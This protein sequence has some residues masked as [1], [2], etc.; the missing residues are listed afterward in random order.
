MTRRAIDERWLVWAFFAVVAG[1]GLLVYDDYGISWDEPGLVHY[2]NLLLEH[3]GPGGEWETYSNLRYYGPVGPVLLAAADKVLPGPALPGVH[4]VSFAFFLAGAAAFY[5]LCRYQFGSRLWGLAG[6]AALVLSPRVFAHGMVNPKDMPLMTMFVVAVYLL[7]RY[8][9][10]RNVWW[11]VACGA[12]TGIAFGIRITG[13]FVAVLVVLGVGID[14]VRRRDKEF[15]RS[16]A[17]ALAA[18]FAF[19]AAVGYAVWPFLWTDPVGNLRETFEVMTNFLEGPPVLL[20]RGD[21]VGV[22]DLPWHYLFVWIG[23]TTPPLYLLVAAAGLFPA[24]RG[25]ARRTRERFFTIHLAWLLVPL[26]AVAIRRPPLY[27]T[28]RQALFVYPALLLLAVAGARALVGFL[29]RRRRSRALLRAAAVF[30]A[31]ALIWIVA[32]MFRLHPYQA[33]YFNVFAG[34]APHDEFE[35]D[36]WGLSYTE[37]Q[38]RLLRAE[39]G[40]LK[41]FN[42]SGPPGGALEEVLSEEDAERIE[43]LALPDEADFSLCTPRPPSFRPFG[44]VAFTIERDG[45]LLLEA[46][47]LR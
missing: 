37:A 40:E 9:D 8:L 34:D 10:S 14:V 46:V 7:V 35:A 26:A 41:V 32:T 4:L 44:H 1:F 17:I 25:V 30:V 18:Y 6:A 39:E 31:C 28:G 13:A 5:A 38:E 16:A 12:A 23:I 22:A 15:V 29:R 45:V 11:I 24:V 43:Y 33:A 36:Y 20:Y 47:R 27:E 3:F 21:T 2:G 42:C 19:F